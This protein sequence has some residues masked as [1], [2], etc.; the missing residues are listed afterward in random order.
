[1]IK[2]KEKEYLKIKQQIR[3]IYALEV[4]IE[5]RLVESKAVRK[6]RGR[7]GI[8]NPSIRACKE[9]EGKSPAN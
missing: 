7:K 1:M 8:I 9:E 6:L 5:K 4:V 3:A 2:K